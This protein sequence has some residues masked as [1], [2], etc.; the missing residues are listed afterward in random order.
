MDGQSS[1]IYDLY[2]IEWFVALWAEKPVENV[3]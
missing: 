2:N 1:G 3:P